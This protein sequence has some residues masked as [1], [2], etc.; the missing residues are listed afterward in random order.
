MLHG[1]KVI[2]LKSDKDVGTL[3]VE[4]TLEQPFWKNV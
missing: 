4:F 2:I 1:T 3:N